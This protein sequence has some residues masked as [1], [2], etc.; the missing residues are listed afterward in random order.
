MEEGEKGREGSHREIVKN[1]LSK[2]CPKNEF[3]FW[4]VQAQALG[5]ST[6]TECTTKFPASRGHPC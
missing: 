1:I 5:S 2:S 4:R 6:I 3:C